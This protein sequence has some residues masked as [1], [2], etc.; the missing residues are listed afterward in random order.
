MWNELPRHPTQCTAAFPGSVDDLA[1]ISPAGASVPAG[2]KALQQA[3]WHSMAAIATIS[4]HKT[5][6]Q[7]EATKSCDLCCRLLQATSHTHKEVCKNGEKRAGC[8]KLD[9]A[10]AHKKLH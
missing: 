1:S 10:Q 7:S 2:A 8:A 3:V 5:G 9:G 6:R 4:H